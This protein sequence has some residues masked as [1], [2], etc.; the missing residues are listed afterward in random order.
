[1]KQPKQQQYE[2]DL[3]FILRIKQSISNG[4][5]PNFEELERIRNFYAKKDPIHRKEGM[6]MMRISLQMRGFPAELL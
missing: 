3:T 6:K 1:M 4:I 5:R 2:S